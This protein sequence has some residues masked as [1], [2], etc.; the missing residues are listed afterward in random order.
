MHANKRIG[1]FNMKIRY[2]F[3]VIICCFFIQAGTVYAAWE[4]IHVVQDPDD[5]TWYR[6]SRDENGTYWV[7][8]LSKYGQELSISEVGNPSPDDSSGTSS[9]RLTV[10]DLK[11]MIRKHNKGKLEGVAGANT[12][13]D[14]KLSR[15][16]KGLDPIWN[17]GESRP[18]DGDAGS[19]T[20]K[21]DSAWV[22]SQ[23]KKGGK[24]DDKD[25]EDEKDK[26]KPGNME[27]GAP[28]I[29]QKGSL[30]QKEVN[31]NPVGNQTR[32]RMGIRNVSNQTVVQFQTM[33]QQGT[34]II[35]EFQNR[36]NGSLAWS[37][38]NPGNRLAMNR[39]NGGGLTT[40]SI[41]NLPAGQWR[42]RAMSDTS[43]AQWSDW[44]EFSVQA[45][46]IAAQPQSKGEKQ[47]VTPTVS[48]GMK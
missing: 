23:A 17:P 28:K 13:L 47:A 45:P 15:Q 30:K 26:S 11:E 38:F 19:A 7:E 48:G 10:T 12:P 22:Q 20:N 8:H 3:L 39:N 14:Q 41:A 29:G 36:A 42:V 21:K 24:K 6:L 5:Q 16:G 4:T 32:I 43:G 31:P 18:A 44:T 34:G 46:S 2:C 1:S 35:V 33:H 9:A 40:C 25:D 27:G 37:G